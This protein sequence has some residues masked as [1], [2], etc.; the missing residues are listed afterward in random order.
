M[1]MMIV[2]QHTAF[3]AFQYVYCIVKEVQEDIIVQIIFIVNKKK[4]NGLKILLLIIVLLVLNK[5]HCYYFK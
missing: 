2:V 5:T 4:K 3:I 1:M